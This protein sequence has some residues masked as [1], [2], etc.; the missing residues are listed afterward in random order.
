MTIQN[1]DLLLV[2]RGGSNYKLN[3]EDIMSIQDTDLM[4]ISRAG[5]NYKA[6]GLEVKDYASGGTPGSNWQQVSATGLPTAGQ[7]NRLTYGN[8]KWVLWF[9]GGVQLNYYISTDN[10]D[11]W[12]VANGNA[13]NLTNISYDSS[14]GFW[15]GWPRNDGTCFQS[16]DALNWTTRGN[17]VTSTAGYTGYSMG[18]S[19]AA[20]GI[21][22]SVI[23]YTNAF[24]YGAVLV[25]ASNDG[26]ATWTAGGGSQ[27]NAW[28]ATSIACS[29]TGDRAMV[30]SS[31]ADIG[32]TPVQ[33]GQMAWSFTRSPSVT[34]LVTSSVS[35]STTS[36]NIVTFNKTMG[37]ATLA[38]PNQV[39]TFRQST[40]SAGPYATIPSAL[41]LNQPTTAF[42]Q[43][44]GNVWCIGGTGGSI[45][46]SYDDGLT[47]TPSNK[48]YDAATSQ[49]T[50]TGSDS[51]S[52]TALIYGG[53]ILLRSSI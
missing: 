25:K 6:T 45:V 42:Y 37:L 35:P 50:W 30:A 17:V 3:A 32:A 47:W 7:V 53:G 18:P 5:T 39:T 4:L 27:T 29:P 2:S 41:G 11:T 44:V 12:T 14:T 26:G 13:T 52:T 43:P 38:I 23:N 28:A 48:Q 24:G 46:F 33:T 1:T 22:F 16:T 15:Y 31:W 49:I 21:I 9:S 20:N 51:S 8:G 40:V 34:T 10:G 19:C 36:N